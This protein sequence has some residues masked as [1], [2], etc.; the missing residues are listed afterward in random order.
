MP[1]LL[2]LHVADEPSVWG[3]IGF[4]VDDGRVRIGSTII[5]F[6]DTEPSTKPGIVGWTL[7]G[8]GPADIDGLITSYGGPVGSTGPRAAHKNGVTSIDHLVVS[9]PG[10][11]RTA[12]VLEGN[13]MPCRRRR[14]GAAYGID[15]MRQAFFWLGDGAERVLLEVVGPAT[16]DPSKADDPAKF[17]GLAVVSA[18]LDATCAFYGD[19]MKPPTS[20]VQAGRRITTLSSRSGCKVSLAFMSSHVSLP[21]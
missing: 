6:V 11:E 5:E 12:A 18:D 16:V 1:S 3:Q 15:K 4:S 7:D 14:D 9:T 17:F 2:T 10:L 19:L 13:G 20:A 8:S 21:E